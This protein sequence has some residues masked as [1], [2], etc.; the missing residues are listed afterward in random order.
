MCEL[1]ELSEEEKADSLEIQR[2]KYGREV[3]WGGSIVLDGEKK[4]ICPPLNVLCLWEKDYIG[5]AGVKHGGIQSL[6]S[7]SPSVSDDDSYRRGRLLV[8]IGDSIVND[9]T[10][11]IAYLDQEPYPLQIS[12]GL[13]EEEG[14]VHEGLWRA[15]G[16]L[17]DHI[18]EAL[19]LTSPSSS[20]EDMID[21]EKRSV[22]NEENES[23]DGEES[24]N[25]ISRDKMPAVHFVGRSLGGGVASLAAAI[26]DGSLPYPVESARKKK[27]RSSISDKKNEDNVEKTKRITTTVDDLLPISSISGYGRGRTSAFVLGAP[28]TLSANIR[29]IFVTALIHGDDIVCRTTKESIDRLSGRAGQAM[30]R[31]ILTKNI[32]WMADTVS[33]TVS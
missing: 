30:K 1:L 24:D 7:S 5:E 15:A 17:L 32:G 14:S 27:R 18:R 13:V 19:L 8:I 25:E 26:L 20:N 4:K 3:V 28:P 6:K 11:T 23:N 2:Q 22:G 16:K 10:Q 12:V 21:E 33:L 29:A 9:L 31:G